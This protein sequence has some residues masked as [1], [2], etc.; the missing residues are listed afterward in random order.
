[1]TERKVIP[2]D[3]EYLED[4]KLRLEILR[5]KLIAAESRADWYE[6]L[7]WDTFKHERQNNGIQ[8]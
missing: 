8:S 3:Q 5:G 6:Q 1:M 7:Y 2:M 4:M